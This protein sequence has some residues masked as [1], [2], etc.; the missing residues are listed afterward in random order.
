[1][2]LCNSL[3]HSNNGYTYSDW[4]LPSAYEVRQ[5]FYELSEHPDFLV[6]STKEATISTSSEKSES[7]ITLNDTEYPGSEV[8]HNFNT[9]NMKT[10]SKIR[11]IALYVLPMRQ[12]PCKTEV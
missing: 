11:S 12:V 7:K 3:V 1:M 9:S 5:A 6:D 10:S 4:F 8:M 2:L